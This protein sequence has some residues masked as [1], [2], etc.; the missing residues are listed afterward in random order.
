M[1]V[2]APLTWEWTVIC[3]IWVLRM[4][5]QA[6]GLKQTSTLFCV[7]AK[8][9]ERRRFSLPPCFIISAFP[10]LRWN[11]RGLAWPHL[12]E[13]QLR[14]GPSSLLSP[15]PCCVL[16]RRKNGPNEHRCSCPRRLRMNML[17]CNRATAAEADVEDELLLFTERDNVTRRLLLDSNRAKRGLPGAGLSPW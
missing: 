2:F 14:S 17:I 9:A 1:C 12:L 5:A 3:G 10:A 7:K 13:P 11:A 6:A 4:F 16:W 15:G 8:I